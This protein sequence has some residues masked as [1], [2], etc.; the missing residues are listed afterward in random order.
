VVQPVS[1]FE[2]KPTFN[3]VKVDELHATAER[4]LSQSRIKVFDDTPEDPQIGHVVATINVWKGKLSI[5]FIVQ[6]KVELYQQ[7][8]LVRDSR[9]QILTSTWPL[10]EETL[11]A[12]MPVIVTRHEI[13][14]TVQHEVETQVKALIADYLE[15][16]PVPEPKPDISDMMTGTIRYVKIEGGCYNIF[17]DDRVEYHPVNLPAQYRRHGLRVA[18]RAVRSDLGGV[19][20][21]GLWIELTRIVKL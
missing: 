6:V 15:A 13:V 21:P 2:D 14:R 1:G 19:P 9:V 5:D 3:P 17:A 16:N 10:G 18:F 12:P 8:T 20:Y 11:E 7:A 4:L